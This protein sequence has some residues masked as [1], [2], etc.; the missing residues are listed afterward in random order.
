MLSCILITVT[1]S[2]ISLH[3]FLWWLHQLSD[4]WAHLHQLYW[5]SLPDLDFSLFV[6]K[7]ML[8]RTLS[9][10]DAILC[11]AS[12]SHAHA[13]GP[14]LGPTYLLLGHTP[15]ILV[16]TNN[17]GDAHNAWVSVLPHTWHCHL[18]ILGLV[19]GIGLGTSLAMLRWIQDVPSSW[20]A[21]LTWQCYAS[22]YL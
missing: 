5:H 3:V 21:I 19:W 4:I 1:C 8:P 22:D 10:I 18:P 16:N 9:L 7:A 20:V 2:G 12:A 13:L 6:H 15:S 11:T 17:V 14:P